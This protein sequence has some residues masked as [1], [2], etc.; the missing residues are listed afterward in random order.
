M[1]PPREDG[2]I[3]R[4]LRNISSAFNIL[5]YFKRLNK[6]ANSGLV[7][8]KDYKKGYHSDMKH[9][10]NIKS[11]FSHTSYAFTLAEVLITLGI[12]GVVA[13]I[14]IP[15]LINNYKRQEYSARIKKFYSTMSQAIVRSEMD[16]GP[17]LYWS[18]EAQAH[19]DDGSVDWDGNADINASFMKK[20]FLPYIKY[21]KADNETGMHSVDYYTVTMTDGSTFSVH[22]GDCMEFMYDINGLKKPPNSDG[23]DTF[24]FLMCFTDITRINYFNNK[25]KFFGTYSYYND[26][27]SREE[28]INRCK[29]TPSYCSALLET[30]GWE[31][32]KDY[33]LRL[34]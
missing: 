30:D 19:S 8:A 29:T 13:A 31:F 21:L 4:I 20:Y 25:N 15:S 7:V 27:S 3:A 9:H 10:K 5:K 22:N 34:R 1:P 12:I 26:T 16:N 32:K 33:P 24:R 18:K 2:F 14:T 17:A 28:M 23:Y 11:I 6:F